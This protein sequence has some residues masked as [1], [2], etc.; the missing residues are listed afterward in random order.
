M[1]ATAEVGRRSA[2]GWALGAGVV[3]ALGFL[4]AVLLQSSDQLLDDAFIFF[5]YVDNLLAGHGLTWNPGGER[6][7]GYTSF[8]W[9]MLLAGP[10]ALGAEPVLLAQ[11]LNLALFGGTLMLS[12]RMLARAAGGWRPSLLF[13]SALLATAATLGE[14]ARSG[15]ELMLFAFLTVAAVH[16]HVEA[17]GVRARFLT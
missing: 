1:A 10:R 13:A 7:E 15:M 2:P 6:V 8:L 14:A 17:R 3:L 12:F 9:V 11:V 16:L 4:N 5:R